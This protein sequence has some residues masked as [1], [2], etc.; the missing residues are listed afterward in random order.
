METSPLL[1]RIP[2][3]RERL[4][5]RVEIV[6]EILEHQPEVPESDIHELVSTA[7]ELPSL[8][9]ELENELRVCRGTLDRQQRE[10]TDRL[11]DL[12]R[13]LAHMSAQRDRAERGLDGAQIRI[14]AL[15]DALKALAALQQT[16]VSG[17]PGRT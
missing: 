11:S 17:S 5:E 6:R 4:T 1:R 15:E 12:E 2:Q 10:S 13:Q 14:K 3:A 16:A 9:R 7:A 8:V